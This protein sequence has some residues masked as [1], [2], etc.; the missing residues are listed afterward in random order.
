MFD[1]PIWNTAHFSDLSIELFLNSLC[2]ITWFSLLEVQLS[3][4]VVVVPAVWQSESVTH[5]CVCGYVTELLC[6]IAGTT[7]TL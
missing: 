2:S 4:N 1:S 6:H 5:V 3:N 7:T